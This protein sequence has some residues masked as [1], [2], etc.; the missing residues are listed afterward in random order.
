MVPDLSIINWHS[1]E[2][3]SESITFPELRACLLNHGQ[4]LIRENQIVSNG[5]NTQSALHTIKS[6]GQQQRWNNSSWNNRIHGQQSCFYRN[7]PRQFAPSIAQHYERNVATICSVIRSTFWE[8]FSTASSEFDSTESHVKFVKKANQ[9]ANNCY[10][11][12]ISPETASWHLHQLVFIYL[13]NNL[14]LQTHN[15]FQA[16]VL[17]VTWLLTPLFSNN[18]RPT[19]HHLC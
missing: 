12:Y 7:Q 13:R 11:R 4:R 6:R 19:L 15:G 2:T 17:L 18:H 10:F 16:Q 5:Q 3:R 1:N 14:Y 9:S 8:K